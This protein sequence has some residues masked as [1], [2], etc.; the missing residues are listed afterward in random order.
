[1]KVGITGHQSREGI[2]WEWVKASIRDEL[3]KLPRPIEGY[4]SLAE[5]ADQVFA[6]A[7][8]DAGGKLTGVIPKP[9]Y[10][11]HFK[12]EA[13]RNYVRLK[14]RSRLEELA[15]EASDEA[16][17]FN[18]GRYIADHTNL[19]F[20]VWDGAPSKGHGGT[21]DVVN[22]ALAKQRTVIH[23]D[24]IRKEVRSLVRA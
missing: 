16:S 15:P 9:D 7:V 3:Q 14:S 20:A 5:G 1:M 8:L 23:I 18:A 6:Q 12:P 22:Y 24:P 13:L 17:F 21:A 19:L 10:E 4:S 11:V 2:D